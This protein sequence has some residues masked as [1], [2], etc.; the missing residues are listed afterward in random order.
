MKKIFIC[1]F[2]FAILLG[3]SACSLKKETPSDELFIEKCKQI[4][5]EGDPYLES[6]TVYFYATDYK[7]RNVFE[8]GKLLYNKK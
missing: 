8:Y 2:S 4:G 6:D 3:L 7:D 1:L 5:F